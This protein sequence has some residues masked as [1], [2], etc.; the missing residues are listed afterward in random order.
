[1][2]FALVNVLL[3]TTCIFVCMRLAATVWRRLSVAGAGG[4]FASNEFR[5]QGVAELAQGDSLRFVLPGLAIQ[6]GHD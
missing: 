6:A 1:M 2:S 5:Q 4:E 3:L